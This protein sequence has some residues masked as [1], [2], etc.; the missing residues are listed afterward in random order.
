MCPLHDSLFDLELNADN[1]VCA[2]LHRA[3]GET[4]RALPE[5]PAD[6]YGAI[7]AADREPHWNPAPP[8]GVLPAAPSPL[9]DP[10]EELLSQHDAADAQRPRLDLFESVER[11]HTPGAAQ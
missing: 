11:F 3:G 7:L 4:E 2:P 10:D 8:R 1:G 9:D 5:Q 6:R